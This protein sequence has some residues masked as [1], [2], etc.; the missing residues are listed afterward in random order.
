MRRLHITSAAALAL[1]LIGVGASLALSGQP[2]PEVTLR[3]LSE[4]PGQHRLAFRDPINVPAGR[5]NPAA[6]R[7]IGDDA[8]GKPVYLARVGA[9][10]CM[11]HNVTGP[12]D[13][14]ATCSRGVPSGMEV[15]AWRK[16]SSDA[17][18]F[19]VVVA[20][21][22]STVKLDGRP[23]RAS[24]NAVLVPASA[25]RHVARAEGDGVTSEEKSLTL[26]N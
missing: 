18:T 13:F 2:P 23:Y 7:Y 25:G 1:A 8:T 26:W 11:L 5:I 24:R 6:A 21:A 22:Y 10:V 14:G 9:S 20:D 3:V 15:A 19:A 16:E 12:Q 17:W 4:P